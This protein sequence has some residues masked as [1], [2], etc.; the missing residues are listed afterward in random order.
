MRWE[1]LFSDIEAQLDESERLELDDEIAVRTR[2]VRKEI[3]LVDRLRSARGRGI[4][5]RVRGAG[6]VRGRLASVVP[7]W[8]L[9][10]DPAG[11]EILVPRAAVLTVSGAGMRAALHGTDAPVVE[12]LLGQALSAVSQDRASVVATLVD[13]SMMTGT[14][15]RVGGDF[16]DVV[17]RLPGEVRA[18][19][20]PRVAVPFSALAT[21]RRT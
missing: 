15:D 21:L 8:L 10:D 7:S 5:V 12:P 2:S 19:A 9:I 16:F 11:S 14:V 1:R 20:D 18:T 3:Y 6:I 17:G 4:E 13:G